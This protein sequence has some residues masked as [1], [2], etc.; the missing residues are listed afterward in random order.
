MVL[1]T[2]PIV[3][4]ILGTSLYLHQFWDMIT[5]SSSRIH[6]DYLAT[7]TCRRSRAVEPWYAVKRRQARVE[8]TEAIRVAF[9]C[10]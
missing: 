7:F 6:T 2:R 3:G 10:S 8:A 1:W 5:I 4:R 9:P